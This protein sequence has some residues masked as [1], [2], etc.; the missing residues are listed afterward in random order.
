MKFQK[1]QNKNTKTLLRAD[2]LFYTYEG[3]REPA[4]NGLSLTVD[5]GKKIACMGANGSGKSTFFLC[6][7]GILKP[8]S[9]TLY[10]D[11]RPFDY[12][13]KELLSLRRKVGIVFQD[14]DR[15]LFC[16]SVRQ[17]IS[18]GPLNLGLSEEEARRRTDAVMEELG[19]T[20]YAH[21]PVHALSGGQK[22]L[23]SIADILVMEPELIILDEPAAALDPFY[24]EKIHQIT[25]RITEK[26][27]TVMMA[28]HDVDHAYRWA[29][30]IILF[31]EGKVLMQDDPVRL[32][33]SG[34]ILKKAH[35]APP[36]LLTLYDRL[37]ENRS[38]REDTPPPRDI[39]EF[40][41][42]LTPQEE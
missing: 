12:S 18:F 9:G 4:L 26:N 24:T 38:V 1:D 11:G 8:S 10:F 3:G 27:I 20:A 28:A 21:K 23:V 30:E 17:E 39:Q 25:R 34:G 16:A 36:A 42:C 37:R 41:N 15:Q 13:K 35:L 40:I 7:N 31:D 6:C 33:S 19:I 29:D 5:R 14:P 2:R 32:F 22:K